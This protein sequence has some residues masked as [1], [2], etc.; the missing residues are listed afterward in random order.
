MR[1]SARL[2]RHAAAI[3]VLALSACGGDASDDS[4]PSTAATSTAAGTSPSTAGGTTGTTAPGTGPATSV[5]TG[6][7][8][9]TTTTAGEE[10][11]ADPEATAKAK[12]QAALD[13]LPDTWSGSIASDL[14]EEGDDGSDIVFAPCLAPGDYDLDQLDADSAASWE[15]DAEGPSVGSPFGGQQAAIEARVFS[16]DADAD[17]AFAVL[18]AVLG[19]DAGHACLAAQV[20]GQLAA[21]APDDA[22]FDASVEGPS[23]TGADVGAR[24]VVGF[25]ADGFSGTFYVDLV[26]TRVGE[27]CTV[28]GTFV[29]FG[30][31]VDEEVASDAFVAAVAATP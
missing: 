6:P 17:S 30:A 18:E 13:S 9:P 29:S 1:A 23:V 26:A 3:C 2:R 19:T 7:G 8:N 20:P 12:V 31:P 14:G 25:N 16:P 11:I 21:G 5:T 10:V 27:R 4:S 15:L 24:L 22:E 28:F